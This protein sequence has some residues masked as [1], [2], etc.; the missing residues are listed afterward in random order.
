[1]LTGPPQMVRAARRQHDLHGG[2]LRPAPRALGRRDGRGGVRLRR[3]AQ[4][5]GGA[6]LPEGP[7][8]VAPQRDDD[9]HALQ[10]ALGHLPAVVPQQGVLLGLAPLRALHVAGPVPRAGREHRD[11]HG[12]EREVGVP[13]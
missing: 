13:W 9:A 4:G 7:G 12:E 6:E 1:M 8:R 11:G 10:R 3:Q 2:G 5:Q